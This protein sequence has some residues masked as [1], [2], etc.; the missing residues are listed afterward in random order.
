MPR[1]YLCEKSV[2]YPADE[3]VYRGLSFWLNEESA[4]LA[5]S[6]GM[7]SSSIL[8]SMLWLWTTTKKRIGLIYF[9]YLRVLF[10]TP[11]SLQRVRGKI[12]KRVYM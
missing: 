4:L 5:T 3:I 2:L 12:I 8:I 10:Q 11:I 1:F 6:A 9:I 7:I